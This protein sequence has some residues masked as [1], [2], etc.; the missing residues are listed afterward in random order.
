[1]PV[2]TPTKASA[3]CSRGLTR[4]HTPIP[5]VPPIPPSLSPSTPIAR[6]RPPNPV[7]PLNPIHPHRPFW[8]R[9]P[10]P[11]KEPIFSPIRTPYSPCGSFP[12]TPSTPSLRRFVSPL[13][14]EGAGVA[15]PVPRPGDGL[16]PI[17][18]MIAE[19]R[20]RD[21]RRG[22]R[23]RPDTGPVYRCEACDRVRLFLPAVWCGH[24]VTPSRMKNGMRVVYLNPPKTKKK[25]HRMGHY[26]PGKDKRTGRVKAKPVA[27][28]P[29]AN[30][31]VSDEH[32]ASSPAVKAQSPKRV[33]TSPTVEPIP[34]PF[35]P[36]SP[37]VHTPFRNPDLNDQPLHWSPRMFKPEID[38]HN[39]T[40]S[41]WDSPS[42]EIED[43]T[44]QTDTWPIRDPFARFP[45][46]LRKKLQDIM[47]MKPKGTPPATHSTDSVTADSVR[48]EQV[49]IASSFPSSSDKSIR[50]GSS[51][52][53]W[54]VL[55]DVPWP[56][57]LLQMLLDAEE[58]DRRL[59]AKG[60]FD[61]EWANSTIQSASNLDVSHHS[62]RERSSSS[63]E[64]LSAPSTS[65]PDVS[66]RSQ[67][68][69]LSSW[70]DL[71]ISKWSDETFGMYT[72]LEDIRRA[73]GEDPSTSSSEASTHSA[74][75]P[76]A[77]IRSASPDF[78]TWVDIV[79]KKW[80]DQL[81]TV[82][83]GAEER[84]RAARIEALNAAG[85]S[86]HSASGSD[87]STHSS[88]TEFSTYVDVDEKKWS[89]QTFDLFNMMDEGRRERAQKDARAAA[90]VSTL[91]ASDSDTSDLSRS[92]EFSPWVRL[93]MPKW[94]DDTFQ[95]YT[96]IEE[97]RRRGPE[98][99][100]TTLS[101]SSSDASLPLNPDVHFSAQQ[102]FHS[103]QGP[104]SPSP[105]VE[106]PS[107]PVL[108][109]PVQV[110]HHTAPVQQFPPSRRTRSSRH[111]HTMRQLPSAPLVEP[112][113]SSEEPSQGSGLGWKSL[114]CVAAAAAAVGAGLAYWF[115][116]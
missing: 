35:V 4:S 26:P 50:S 6:L 101:V 10:T 103:L 92:S 98:E 110:D 44:Y 29:P 105:S 90:G 17:S 62:E 34:A 7:T 41:D 59:A 42:R 106:A 74:S 65:G 54:V 102:H 1:M 63:S 113:Q 43:V 81:F 15:R 71:D 82:I 80:T 77:S 52:S 86:T 76:D 31:E 95:I 70:I 89:D 94:S 69:Q 20:A 19:F 25:P 99:L 33:V 46:E 111:F 53:S 13:H 11:F 24:Q 3:A 73:G 96:E 108:S 84:K 30:D 57:R 61:R 56:P 9:T 51:D 22:G 27:A 12:P 79:E 8:T 67:S 45:P 93:K 36:S 114:A 48:Y 75:I 116:G 83:N 23:E 39:W 87:A 91:F 58:Q 112:K 18:A 37:T 38:R 104:P 97:A 72:K 60:F 64:N 85:A 28:A 78:S 107:I 14:P 109:Q 88:S 49:D 5:P 21:P 68:P 32:V 16:S 40:W 2:F 66:V 55:N 47:A 100:S 115:S